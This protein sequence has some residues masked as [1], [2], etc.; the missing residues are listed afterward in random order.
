[1]LKALADETRWR[2]VRY[3]LTTER[4]NVTMLTVETKASQPSISKH[5]RILRRAGIVTSEKEATVVWCSITPAF[6]QQLQDGETVLD[7]GCCTFRFGAL[8]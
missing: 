1:M 4:A 8:A 2:I 3:L 5:L 7:L 6:R